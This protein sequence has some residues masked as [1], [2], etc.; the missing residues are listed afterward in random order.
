MWRAMNKK[1]L[2]IE[3]TYRQMRWFLFKDSS[4]ALQMAKTWRVNCKNL[5]NG[6]SFV[7]VVT[8][9]LLSIKERGQFPCNHQTV[10]H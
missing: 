7:Y 8:W 4:V 1:W 10:T 9:C 6:G 5:K 3:L 2:Y